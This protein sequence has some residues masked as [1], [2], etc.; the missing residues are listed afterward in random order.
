MFGSI[1]VLFI[2]RDTE[3]SNFSNL[4]SSILIQVVS[5]GVVVVA[6]I[7]AAAVITRITSSFSRRGSGRGVA[8]STQKVM[9][10]KM[11]IVCGKIEQDACFGRASM[12]CSLLLADG[13]KEGSVLY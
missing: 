13:W 7:V 9:V 6:A 12:F 10:D 8:H 11:K 1:V 5:E 3:V 2:A 4:F